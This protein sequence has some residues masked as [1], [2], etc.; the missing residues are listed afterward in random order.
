MRAERDIDE[1]V[2]YRPAR[3]EP[4]MAYEIALGIWLGGM[5]LGISW[6]LVALL[7]AG[8]AMRLLVR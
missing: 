3:K 4:R 1:V 8:S 5:A 2:H 6:G 7:M